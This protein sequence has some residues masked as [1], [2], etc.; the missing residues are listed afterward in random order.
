MWCI[1]VHNI[2]SKMFELITILPSWLATVG[3]DFYE[4]AKLKN[5]R[6]SVKSSDS[7][8]ASNSFTETVHFQ[9]SNQSNAMAEK[10]WH[11]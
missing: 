4:I 1:H 2:A 11:K 10:R 9:E 3:F 7:T 5:M 6:G 8:A